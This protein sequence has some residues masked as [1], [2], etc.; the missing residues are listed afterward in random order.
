MG[1]EFGGNAF[2]YPEGPIYP[3]TEWHPHV[4]DP[5]MVAK[6]AELSGVTLETINDPTT[7]MSFTTIKK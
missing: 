4:C 1:T 2:T 3:N 5:K 6:H 7:G